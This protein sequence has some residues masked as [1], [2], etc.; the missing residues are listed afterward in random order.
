[1]STSNYTPFLG[2]IM[3]WK[4]LLKLRMVPVAQKMLENYLGLFTLEGILDFE[5]NRLDLK[6]AL[7]LMYSVNM[8]KLLKLFI[9][10]VA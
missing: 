9:A 5:L 3:K 2:G 6:S 7:L 4:D 8:G 10:S 1:M